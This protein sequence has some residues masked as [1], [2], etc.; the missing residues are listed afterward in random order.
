MTVLASPAPAGE[1]A[2]ILAALAL[3]HN[4]ILTAWSARGPV[5]P[6]RFGTVFSDED[7]ARG[8]LAPQRPRLHAALQ[9]LGDAQEYVLRLRI[10]GAPVPVAPPVEATGR[11]FL[12]RGRA[13]R[14]Q[15]RDLAEQR[16]ALARRLLAEAVPHARQV[17]AAA[18]PRPDRL[19]DVALL[20]DP[21]STAALA[22]LVSR[23]R[24]EATALGLEIG[25]TGPWP[26]YGF[27]EVQLDG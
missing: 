14:D 4:Q 3:T 25:L 19:L 24:P 10:L 13:Q 26:A 1:E 27:T 5:L 23:H 7:V 20:V 9:A 18:A 16:M 22:V 12:A 21:A 15:R 2:E 17:G 11:A 8:H 6:L